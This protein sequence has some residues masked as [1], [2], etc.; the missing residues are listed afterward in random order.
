MAAEFLKKHDC[1]QQWTALETPDICRLTLRGKVTLEECRQI[2]EAHLEYGKDVPYFFYLID[3]SDLEDLPPAVRK[4]ASET[5][6]LLPLRGTVVK[7]APLRAKVLARLL[8]T[9][10]NLFRRGPEANPLVFVETEEEAYA[11]YEKRRQQVSGEAA[12]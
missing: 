7:N 4:E 3:L 6:K 9:A 10:A 5:V 12:A 1:G 8:L 11:W 2:N